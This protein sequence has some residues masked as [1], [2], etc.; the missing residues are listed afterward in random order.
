MAFY[1]M[2]NDFAINGMNEMRKIDYHGTTICVLDDDEML[3]A[4][5]MLSYAVFEDFGGWLAV[6][7]EPGL[8][9]ATLS[10]FSSLVPGIDTHRKTTKV[11][12]IQLFAAFRFRKLGKTCR[13]FELFGC[14]L[15]LCYQSLFPLL[16]S[17]GSNVC[18]IFAF[19]ISNT[20]AHNC[21]FCYFDWTISNDRRQIRLV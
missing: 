11:D 2:A 1:V 13:L 19:S 15:A 7:I 12:Q 16:L 14:F 4:C 18:R 17:C 20:R 3:D 21:L 9:R 5:P 8:N 6:K 10:K